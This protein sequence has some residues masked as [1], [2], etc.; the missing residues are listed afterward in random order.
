M[1]VSRFCEWD[2]NDTQY[3]DL[4]ITVK[5]A[6]TSKCTSFCNNYKP[7]NNYNPNITDGCYK[8]FGMYPGYYNQK[9]PCWVNP[10]FKLG[11][12]QGPCTVGTPSQALKDL[13]KL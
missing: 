11:Y 3:A 12:Y 4:H 10:I 5:G 7:F 1:G 6:C 13:C 9:D 8:C 2:E